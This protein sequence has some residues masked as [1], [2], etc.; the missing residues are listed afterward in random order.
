MNRFQFSL[1]TLLVAVL[2]CAVVLCAFALELRSGLLTSLFIT[3]HAAALCLTLVG[4]IVM[5]GRMRLVCLGYLVFGTAYSWATM[6]EIKKHPPWLSDGIVY[7]A[8]SNLQNTA[9]SNLVS[10]W[11]SLVS[12]IGM[13]ALRTKRIRIGDQ[14]VIIGSGRI[15][16]SIVKKVKQNR[17]GENSYLLAF[18]N[19]DVGHWELESQLTRID[20]TA[21]YQVAGH[22]A[23]TPVAGLFGVWLTLLVFGRAETSRQEKDAPTP[24]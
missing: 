9:G 13:R 16:P 6:P 8:N 21:K 15:S 5:R 22:A 3:G 4:A 12:L 11:S 24:R 19:S 20:Q 14:V 23:V 7:V 1:R 10:H 17:N 18:S 2:C